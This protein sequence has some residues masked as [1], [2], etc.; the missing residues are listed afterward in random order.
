MIPC[1]SLLIQPASIINSTVCGL[2]FMT[3]FNDKIKID[4][5]A[6]A[7]PDI[8]DKIASYKSFVKPFGV[9]FIA[10]PMAWVGP[11]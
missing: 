1:C 6:L 4:A 7:L 10:R 11:F 9:C 2:V 8:S 3:S 5:Y